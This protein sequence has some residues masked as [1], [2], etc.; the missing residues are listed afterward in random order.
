MD[1]LFAYGTLRYEDEEPSFG[2]DLQKYLED[3]YEGKVRGHLYVIEG[4]PFLVNE[5][6]DWIRG[7]L[8]EF[9]DIDPILEKYD[10]IEGADKI[11]PFFERETVEVYMDDGSVENAHCYV[12]GESLRN[13]FAKPEYIVKC[14]DIEETNIDHKKIK[15]SF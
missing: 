4:F 14:G 6:S 8:F 3:S 5:G 9:S 13:Y 10:K 2:I 1:K 11:D 12:G 15:Q 7:K